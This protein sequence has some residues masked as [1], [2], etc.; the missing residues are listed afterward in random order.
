MNTDPV[1]SDSDDIVLLSTNELMNR[2]AN[3]L[4]YQRNKGTNQIGEI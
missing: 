2:R 1:N 3:E 4:N